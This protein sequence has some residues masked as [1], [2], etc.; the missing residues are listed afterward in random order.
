MSAQHNITSTM[1]SIYGT[2]NFNPRR[3]DHKP[4]RS[5]RAL[6]LWG[7]GLFLFA[8]VAVVLG[9]MYLFGRTPESFTGNRVAFELAGERAPKTADNVD[10]TLKITNNEEVDLEDLELFID[11]P[12][13][14]AD[15]GGSVAHF[16]A[17]ATPAASE[18]NNTWKLGNVG[19]GTSVDFLFTARF[20]GSAGSQVVIPFSLS[21][22]PTSL[23]S[24]YTASHQETFTLGDPTVSIVLLA[25]SV[26]AAGSEVTLSVRASGA[27]LSEEPQDA[28]FVE[29]SIPSSFSVSRADP[30]PAKQG[31]YQWPLS[32]LPKTGDAYQLS[33]TGT[34]NAG[35]GETI[36]VRAKLLRKDSSEAIVESEKEISVQDA[37][38]SVRVESSPAQGKKLQW[39]E[40]IDYAVTLKN[41][42]TYVMRNVVVRL[43]L[44]DESLWD[45]DSLN[46]ASGGFYESGNAFWD[47]ATTPA[48]DS[49][50]PDASATLTA[51]LTASERPPRGFAGV[52]RL[53][54]GVEVKA[55]LGDQEVSVTSEE[56]IANILADVQF[57]VAGRY[58]SPEGAVIG[59]GPNPPQLGQETTYVMVWTIGPTTSGLRDLELSARL[60][61]FVSWK[62]DT[63][64][65]VGEISFDGASRKVT[66]KASSI[67]GLELAFDVRFKVSAT[68]TA[69]LSPTTQLLE[70][71]EFSVVDSAVGEGMEFF[72]NAVTLGNIE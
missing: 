14:S 17:S 30:E 46:I 13:E 42:G 49:L 9:G 11:W 38:V 18:A 15:P 52:P 23:S 66:W 69:E 28:V 57:E 71:S 44:P 62:N 8:I 61:S 25:P 47:T 39:G 63:S 26:A 64:L 53:V 65:S 16:V 50:R 19:S 36:T 51:S 41:T 6:Y 37:S 1:R 59:A 24:T 21:F 58:L 29:L 10:Y 31:T 60:P 70:R 54:A 20:G 40:R 5:T 32:A 72:G 35:A 22:R 68:P 67:P 33:L 48:L 55:G 45:S 27:S 4:H 3:F 56:N 2:G 12:D 43:Q 34:V 7:L